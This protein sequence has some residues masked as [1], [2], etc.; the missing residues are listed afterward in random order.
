MNYDDCI[1]KITSKAISIYPVFVLK[2]LEVD[3]KKGIISSK[4]SYICS[5]SDFRSTNINNLHWNFCIY[6]HF[7]AA[8]TLS[9]VDYEW[10]RNQNISSKLNVLNYA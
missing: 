8:N 9:F 7:Y 2:R 3:K 6:V 10:R 1:G 4:T 5:C